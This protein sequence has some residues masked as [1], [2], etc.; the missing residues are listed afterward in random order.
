MSVNC[1]TYPSA[2]L[3][4]AQKLRPCRLSEIPS[5]NLLPGMCHIH[6]FAVGRVPLISQ[7]SNKNQ[8]NQSGIQDPVMTSTILIFT[9]NFSIDCYLSFVLPRGESN[10]KLT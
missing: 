1:S 5:H 10:G 2:S 9:M 8:A 7:K 6:R 3:P 4:S